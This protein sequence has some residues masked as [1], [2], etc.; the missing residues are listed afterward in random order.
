M[1]PS[2]LATKLY[3]KTIKFDKKTD[4]ALSNPKPHVNKKDDLCNNNKCVNKELTRVGFGK[5][6]RHLM[7][8]FSDLKSIKK[9]VRKINKIIPVKSGFKSVSIKDLAPTQSEIRDSRAQ[10]ILNKWSKHDILRQVKKGAPIVTSGSGSVIDGHHRSEAL[11]K[12]VKAGYINDTDTI[13]V[14]AIELPAW[15]ILSMA[16][17]FGYNKQSQP[18]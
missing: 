15:T 11:K 8:Q 2:L 14:Y 18:F 6:P 4:L 17:K 5:L 16:N 1:T 7:P 3:K 9:F 10:D 13:Q 12:A